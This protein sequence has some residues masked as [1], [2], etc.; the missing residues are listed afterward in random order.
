MLGG[1]ETGACRL[2]GGRPLPHCARAG[3][4][5][6]EG[7]ARLKCT[8]QAGHSATAGGREAAP[9][10]PSPARSSPRKTED[11]ASV[12]TSVVAEIPRLP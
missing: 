2:A 10:W 4:P 11:V 8:S 6:R 3:H 9:P 7:R 12:Q 5:V 1:M